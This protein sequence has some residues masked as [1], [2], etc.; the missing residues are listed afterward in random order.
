MTNLNR[1]TQKI[2][3]RLAKPQAARLKHKW[4]KKKKKKKR[5]RK[6]EQQSIVG[7]LFSFLFDLRRSELHASSLSLHHDVTMSRSYVSSHRRSGIVT[8]FVFA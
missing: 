3:K 2:Q 5:K 7:S 4:S 1:E 8:L 6:S